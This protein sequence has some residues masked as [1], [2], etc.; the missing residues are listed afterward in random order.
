MRELGVVGTIVL[1]IV[2]RE[3]VSAVSRRRNFWREEGASRSES[4]V[5]AKG[6][7]FSPVNGHELC[8]LEFDKAV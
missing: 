6:S 4:E 3:R 7:I 2:D 8:S 1:L 5:L